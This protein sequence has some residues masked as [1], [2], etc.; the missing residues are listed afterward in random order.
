MSMKQW[1]FMIL[2]TG[3]GTVG[4]YVI[5]P[6]CG[7]WV[8]YLFGIFRPQYMWEWVLPWG[9]AWSFY[10]AMATLGGAVFVLLGWL[11][12]DFRNPDEIRHVHRFTSR[13]IIFLIFALWIILTAITAKVYDAAEFWL[14]EYLKIFLMYF[15]SA[16][17]VRSVKHIW[18]LFVMVGLVLGYIAY[19][20]NYLYF[21]HKY[22]GIYKRGYGGLDNNGAGLMLAMG[23]PVC[24]FCFEAVNRWWRYFFLLLIPTLVHAVLMTYS[25]GAMLSLLVMLPVM[26]IRSRYRLRLSLAMAFFFAVLLPTMAGPEIK[27]RF[28]TIQQHEID[29]TANLRWASWTAAVRIANDYPIFG[30]GVRNANLYSEAYGADMY[31][32]TIHSQ[33]L[34][35]AADN[36]WVGMALY[37]MLLVSAWLALRRVRILARYKKDD[38]TQRA[39]AIAA[40]VECSL[41]VFCFGA[42]FLSLEVFELPFLLL[43]LCAQLELVSGANDPRSYEPDEGEEESAEEPSELAGVAP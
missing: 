15:V 29:E 16:F 42:L 13:H 43:L 6:F 2:M 40:G 41:I 22:L 32:R 12:A 5:S 8:Y 9:V 10:V 18:L 14:I 30:V 34:Q 35:L 36:G 24:W 28:F 27:A 31:G 25:R 19:E 3:L 17:L 26:L 23:V 33:Y 1:A 4:V 39:R 38:E 21:A 37:L 7:V 20:V 11:P